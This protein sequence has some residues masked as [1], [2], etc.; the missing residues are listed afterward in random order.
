MHNPF[1][2]G[3][4]TWGRFPTEVLW[5]DGALHKRQA[6]R[7][8]PEEARV[9]IRDHHDG[10]IDWRTYEENQRMM[11]GNSSQVGL[12]E[13]VGAVRAGKGLLVGLLRCGRCGRKMYVRYGNKAGTTPR[14]Y[15]NGNMATEVA[16]PCLN[17]GG[18]MID[19]R[20]SEEIVRELSPFGI[21]ASLEAVDRFGAK[22]KEQGQARQRQIE[23]L[24][25]EAIRAFEQYDE[26]DPRNR[27]VASELERRWNEKLE[28]LE[29]ARA[30]LSELELTRAAP[31]AVERERLRKLGE[32]FGDVW[33]DPAC[34]AVLKK[35]IVRSL[36]EEVLVDEEQPG[37]LTFIIH[38]KGGSH[39]S[40]E[41]DKPKPRG[42]AK[43]A[44]EVIEVIRKMAPRYGDDVIA[45]VLNRLGRRTG[46]GNPW[47]QARVKTARRNH[48]IRGHSR[49]VDDPEVMS[50]RAAVRY[51]DTSE[52]TI[53]KLVSAGLLPMQQVVPFAPWELRRSDLDSPALR[54]ILT[55]LEQTG[56]LVLDG[57]T[58]ESQQEL[59][60]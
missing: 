11:R 52:T 22:E 18:A 15:C 27:L 1:Y 5:R 12:D 54:E 2:A 37:N 50:L 53:K 17:F 32:D 7:L 9:F 20:F 42:N 16:G 58:S 23:Q 57:D 39:T 19:Q 25:Y 44:L 41:M 31:S 51:A 3:A 60:Q 21:R 45:L 43:T 29:E 33:N 59:F 28:E 30:A 35:K 46:M 13:S 38:W 40:F 14:Y 49:T 4:Y 55:H 36:L 26:V 8:P 56:K 48:G 47:T 34:P 6:R 24:E 10:Y